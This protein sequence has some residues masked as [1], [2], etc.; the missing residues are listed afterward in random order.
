MKYNKRNPE[1]DS[2]RQ[3]GPPKSNLTH[4]SDWPVAVPA[5]TRQNISPVIE[6]TLNLSLT[7]FFLLFPLLLNTF[8]ITSSFSVTRLRRPF[9]LSYPFS[10]TN[11]FHFPVVHVPACACTQACMY[12]FTHMQMQACT[13]E[14]S[15]SVSLSVSYCKNGSSH[16]PT[17]RP[18]EKSSYFLDSS[19]SDWVLIF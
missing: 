5:V 14:S 3:E 19:S 15:H 12:L 7:G 8:A 11:I 18:H 2:S 10:H 17:C 4:W 13:H 9:V 1:W 16:W 6:L